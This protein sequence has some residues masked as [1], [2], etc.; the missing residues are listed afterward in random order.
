MGQQEAGSRT[1]SMREGG[2]AARRRGG[3]YLKQERLQGFREGQSIIQEKSSVGKTY[4][5]NVC[6]QGERCERRTL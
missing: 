1:E 4:W 5:A 3:V 2:R 6:V